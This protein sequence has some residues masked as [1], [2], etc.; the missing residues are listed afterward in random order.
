MIVPLTAL[1]KSI[2]G[3]DEKNS[4]CVNPTLLHARH[5]AIVDQE[6]NLEQ[7]FDFECSHRSESMFK[8]TDKQ[9]RQSIVKK[10]T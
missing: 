9:T 1:T 3:S 5:A 2:T 8:R 4:L 10:Y 6:E 7:H